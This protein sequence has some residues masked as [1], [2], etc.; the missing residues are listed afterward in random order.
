MA[1]LVLVRLV[2]FPLA[3]S[4]WPVGGPPVPDADDAV[5]GVFAWAALV[6][7][8]WLTAGTALTALALLPGALGRGA[9]RLAS[10]LTP[11][12]VRRALCLLL[13]TGVGTV[14]LPTGPVMAVPAMTGASVPTAPGPGCA[15]TADVPR[16]D[17]APTPAPDPRWRPSRPV[18]AAD[19]EAAAL[20]APAPRTS[21]VPDDVV[22]VRR[23]DSLWSLAARHLGPGA[24][25]REIALMWPHWYAVNADV[26]G[27]DP[28]LIRPGQ[29]LRIPT[30]GGHR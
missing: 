12:L 13:G 2:L 24:T 1:G 18:P 6:I 16:A 4:S 30:L 3:L 29:Q 7:A 11:A 28:D 15:P 20:L 5:S 17:P 9:A 27:P 8:M 19:P 25:D 26:I 10:A 22:T 23:G 21:G 14:S